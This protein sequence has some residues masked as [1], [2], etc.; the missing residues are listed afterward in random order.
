MWRRR[1]RKRRECKME[2]EYSKILERG[3]RRGR[4]G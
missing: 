3:R 4:E 1:R 2:G